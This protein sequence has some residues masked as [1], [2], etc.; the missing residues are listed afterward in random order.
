VILNL[1][2]VLQQVATAVRLLRRSYA[3]KFKEIVEQHLINGIVN[4][5]AWLSHN[6]GAISRDLNL[7]TALQQVTTAVRLLKWNYASKF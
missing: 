3:G 1:L 6:T 2:T 7:L 5:Q 4:C